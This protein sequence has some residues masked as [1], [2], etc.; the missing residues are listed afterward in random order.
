IE[1]VKKGA[2]HLEAFLREGLEAYDQFKPFMVENEYRFRADN[3]RGLFARLSQEE[4]QQLRWTPEKIDWY[5]YWLKVHFP[6]LNKWVFPKMEEIGKPKPKR[7]YTY[8]SLMEMFNAVTKLH[9]DRV[10]LRM[11]RKGK[12]EEYT[13]GD[14]AELVT[15]CATFL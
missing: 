5:Q 9:K 15:R 13:Y 3:V 1:S 2:D 7:I 11:Q 14:L 10:A 12:L 8:R 4:S 6:G